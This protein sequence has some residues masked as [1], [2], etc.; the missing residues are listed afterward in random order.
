MIHYLLKTKDFIPKEYHSSFFDIDFGLL[1]QKG[2]RLLLTDLDNTLISYAE[3]NATKEIIDKI[4]ELKSIGFEV[5]IL[6]N[7]HQPRIDE[8]VKDLDILGYASAHKPLTSGIK[9]A[10]SGASREYSKSEIII[11]GD[12]IMTDIW[13]ANR[14]GSYCILVDP[15]KAKTEKWYTKINRKIEQKMIEKIKNKETKIYQELSLDKR[16]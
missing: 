1:Y 10:V 2:Y 7:N 3:M 4:N 13:G 16:Y 12:Q 11:V 15:I 6:S 8:F 9:K 14:Y 5:A